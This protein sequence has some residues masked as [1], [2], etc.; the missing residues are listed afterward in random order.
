MDYWAKAPRGRDQMVLFSPT[1][2]DVIDEAHPV[3]LL[4][5]IL[6]ACDWREW[7]AQY[8]GHRGQP[9]I[10]PRVVAS[11][12]L[13]GLT[14]GLR[15]SRLLEYLCTH[16]V[17]FMWLVEGRSIDHSTFCEFRTQFRK[18][19]DPAFARSLRTAVDGGW[20]LGDDAFKAEIA[21]ASGRRTAPL[22]RG[23]RPKIHGKA[24]AT[25]DA[26]AGSE[27]P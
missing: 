19:M 7:E 3:R 4:D 15:S 5:E 13:F 8:N 20:V 22:R 21:E 6:A 16:N 1:L 9:P 23:R 17:D 11:V 26:D 2:D 14:R 25:P 24:A 10:R 18:P 12:L 27:Q